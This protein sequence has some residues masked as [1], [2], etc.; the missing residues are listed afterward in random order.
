MRRVE[1][2]MLTVRAAATALAVSYRQ[3]KRIWRRYQTGGAAAV[4]HRHVGRASN[5]GRAAEERA[6]VLALVRDKYSGDRFTR[7]GPTLAAEHLA[8][9]D[10]ITIDHE[11]LRRWLLAAGLWQ[12]RRQRSPYRQRRAR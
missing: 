10:G 2:G 6:R 12:R 8:S 5:R 4:V 7:F 9:E 3:A 1:Q 11:T